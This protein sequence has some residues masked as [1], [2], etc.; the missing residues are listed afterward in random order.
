MTP[1]LPALSLDSPRWSE[2]RH[3]YG[4]AM[5]IPGLLEDV[6][7]GHLDAIG[8]LFGSLCH[9][10]T[11]YAASYASAPHLV[12]HVTSSDWPPGNADA[13][14]SA[15]RA[16]EARANVLILVGAIRASVDYYGEP[17]PEDVAK[18]YQESLA[19]ALTASVELLPHVTDTVLAIYVLEAAASLRG[20]LQL[21]RVLDHLADYELGPSCPG[22]GRQVLISVS[23]D[24]QLQ[25]SAEGLLDTGSSPGILVSPG[26]TIS[27]GR[28]EELKWIQELVAWSPCLGKFRQLLPSLL[29]TVHCP[30]CGEAFELLD[31]F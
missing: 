25:A 16:V 26:P 24:G 14:S 31:G 10:G 28:A 7:E 30:E 29:G 8:E 23:K 9:Q 27:P 6:G 21:G 19:V 18:A 11:T 12:G 15:A 2:L 13:V 3:A 5:D 22:C 1:T 4:P 17:A 20:Y